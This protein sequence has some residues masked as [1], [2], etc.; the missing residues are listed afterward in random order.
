MI[1][2][3]V[4]ISSFKKTGPNKV[5]ENIVR[6]LDKEKFN[7]FVLSYLDTNED[8]AIN[9][10]KEMG[11]TVITL[12]LKSKIDIITKGVKF[13]NQVIEKNNISIVHSH[14]ILPDI[15]N[16]KSKS[17][18]KVTTIHD[19][20]FE[21][22][23]YTFGKLKGTCFVKW[24]L[25]HL[26]RFQKC[27]CC[28]STAFEFLNKRI[29]NCTYIR[30]SIYKEPIDINKY[31]GIRKNIRSKYNIGNGDI[32]YIYAGKLSKLKR[33][34][35]LV[36]FFNQQLQKNHYLFILGNGEMENDVKQIISNKN[37]IFCG[38]CNN[39]E[40]YMIASDIY[41]SF[42]S[43]EGFSIS[44][45]E[46]LQSHNL[47]FLSDIPSHKE[48]FGIDKRYYL[49]EFF[50]NENVSE[51]NER[52]LKKIK[53]IKNLDLDMFLNDNLSI[54]KMS[55]DYEKIYKEFISDKKEYKNESNYIKY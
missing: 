54:A 50:N 2:I 28:S 20:M 48:I 8:D 49:G 34:D 14:G 55:K 27:I 32:V 38:F 31:Y 18:I 7:I 52:I 42:S 33:I 22:Y 4:T 16:S 43:S 25:S 39:V 13:L 5:L 15:S 29:K 6:G 37:I 3:L 47:L 17:L 44:V 41:C 21:D 11:I 51:V 36:I 1:N 46:A 24:H 19:N 40:E 9:I 53:N 30:N 26:K 12:K 45:L 10:L 23:I 35:D